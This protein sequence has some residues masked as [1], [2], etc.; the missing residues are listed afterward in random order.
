MAAGPV[1]ADHPRPRRGV[2][3]VEHDLDREVGDAGEQ[4]GVE[5]RPDHRRQLEQAPGR[6]VEASEPRAD[7]LAHAVGRRRAADRTEG[8][9]AAARPHE[10][11]RVE[12]VL[13]QLDEQEDVAV[14]QAGELVDDAVEAGG[15]GAATGGRDEG[16]DALAV[17]AVHGH[18]HHARRAPQLGQRHAQRL[19]DVGRCGPVRHDD[20]HVREPLVLEQLEQDIDR[21]AGRPLHVVEDEQHRLGDGQGTDRTDHG[22]EQAGSLEVGVDR[23]RAR[24]PRLTPPEQQPAE[25]GT[26]VPEALDDRV[27]VPCREQVAEGVAE[28]L[29]GHGRVLRARAEEHGAAAGVDVAGE[30]GDQPR[31]ARADLAGHEHDLAG[32]ATHGGPRGLEDLPHGGATDEGRRT[33]QR[34]QGRQR[35][36]ADGVLLAAGR[37]GR[38]VGP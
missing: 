4:R 36:G 29:V 17:E 32:A 31:L 12:E 25:L 11:P 20:Q 26:V 7:H 8:D 35:Q 2:E 19:V 23:R 28:R 38:S 21:R 6:R 5:R 22:T 37:H 10:A 14:G 24:R 13:P 27:G 30:L 3:T 16:A 18:P 15:V 1:L 33:G 9:P 34:Q